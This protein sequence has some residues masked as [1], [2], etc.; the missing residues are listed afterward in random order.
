MKQRYVEKLSNH[1]ACSVTQEKI[2]RLL[3]VSQSDRKEVGKSLV[4]LATLLG[5]SVKCRGRFK[6]LY[7]LD[8][9]RF[10]VCAD[11]SAP[12]PVNSFFVGLYDDEG[13][14][15]LGV[16][17]YASDKNLYG[18]SVSLEAVEDIVL[19]AY[20]LT[21]GVVIEREEVVTVK[22]ERQEIAKDREVTGAHFNGQDVAPHYQDDEPSERFRMAQ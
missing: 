11:R 3:G 16:V 21:S 22:R 15:L 20:N 17:S 6:V 4:A 10:T 5:D 7:E 13:D 18:Y 2:F 14:A 8:E 19:P 12:E 9:N 1:L